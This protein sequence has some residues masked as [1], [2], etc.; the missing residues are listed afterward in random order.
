MNDEIEL[1]IITNVILSQSI[2][3]FPS[4]NAAHKQAI[5][6]VNNVAQKSHFLPTFKMMY[7]AIAIAGIS[8]RPARAYFD[9]EKKK[10]FNS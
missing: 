7:I 6:V 3:S 4:E 2:R 10:P 5:P 9:I 8:T 1:P